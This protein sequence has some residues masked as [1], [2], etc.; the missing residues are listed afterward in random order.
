MDLKIAP[1]T[2]VKIVQALQIMAAEG[3]EDARALAEQ[4][5]DERSVPKTVTLTPPVTQTLL[6]A[7]RAAIRKFKRARYDVL[8]TFPLHDGPGVLISLRYIAKTC[9][10]EIEAAAGA[11]DED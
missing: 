10:R 9:R 6:L 2:R 4:L 8:N 7:A 3:D 5:Y 1:Y 11:V